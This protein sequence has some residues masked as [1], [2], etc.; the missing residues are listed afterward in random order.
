MNQVGW[1]Q[2]KGQLIQVIPREQLGRRWLKQQSGLEKHVQSAK[3]MVAWVLMYWAEGS[4]LLISFWQLRPPV[5]GFV[6][7]LLGL[8]EDARVAMTEVVGRSPWPCFAWLLSG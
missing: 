3:M 7:D 5:P 4:P 2:A 6:V 1:L 8:P